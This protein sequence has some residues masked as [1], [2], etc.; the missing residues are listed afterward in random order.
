MP[1]DRRKEQEQGG[2]GKEEDFMYT[3]SPPF[4][5]FLNYQADF[6]D[7]LELPSWLAGWLNMSSIYTYIP[8]D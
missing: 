6:L 5:N 8:L 4:Q 1:E 2:K 3:L 7:V